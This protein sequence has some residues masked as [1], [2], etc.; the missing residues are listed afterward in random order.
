MRSIVQFPDPLA[1]L[2]GDPDCIGVGCATCQINASGTQLDEEQDLD[3]L[4]TDGFHS[5]LVI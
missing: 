5:R 2:L 3:G 1:C 4:Q